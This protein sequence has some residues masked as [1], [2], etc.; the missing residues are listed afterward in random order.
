MHS[1]NFESVVECAGQEANIAQDLRPPRFV[2][3]DHVIR[4][5]EY[6]VTEKL[7]FHQQLSLIT[8]EHHT[9]RIVRHSSNY[10]NF[11]ASRGQ[12]CCDR[13]DTIWQRT[14]FR[15]EKLCDDEDTHA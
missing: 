6:R 8:V 15:Q 12:L 11:V 7:F 4:S 9:L 13:V 1:S 2:A 10:V 5:P 14:H 3:W